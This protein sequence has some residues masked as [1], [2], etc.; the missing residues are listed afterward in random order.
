MEVLMSQNFRKALSDTTA[1]TA[2]RKA[3]MQSRSSRKAS[4][5]LVE[6]D[7]KSYRI[8]FGKPRNIKKP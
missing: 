6:I 2:L 7:G 4:P 1:R 3:L 5:P 8:V